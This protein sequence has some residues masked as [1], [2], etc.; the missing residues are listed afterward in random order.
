M[1]K[2]P[3]KPTNLKLLEGGYILKRELQAE[4]KPR[5]IAPEIPKDIDPAAKKAF[6]I[7]T[8]RL[9]RIGLVTEND[10]DTLGVLCQVRARLEWI[11]RN[12]RSVKR[13]LN[14]EFNPE[15]EKHLFNLM[16]EERYYTQIFRR[17]ASEFG[18]TPRGR[19]GLVV[20]SKDRDDGVELLTQVP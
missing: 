10:G 7:F 4:P 15:L 2:R 9:T 5:P 17:Y 3:S 14:K 13:Q 16:K 19:V 12:M 20:G 18:L 11:Y 6:K 1:S 8:K